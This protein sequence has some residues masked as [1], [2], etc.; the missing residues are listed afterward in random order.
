MQLFR[1]LGASDDPWFRVGQIPATTTVVVSVLGV[2]GMVLWS[3]E[4]PKHAITKYLILNADSSSS[5]VTDGQIWRLLTWPFV[6]RPNILTVLLIAVFW[7]LGSQIEALM[8]R[9]RFTAFVLTLVLLPAVIMSLFEFTPV[10]G[11]ASGL[12][13]LQIS[14]LVAFVTHYSTARFWPGLPGTVLVGILVGLAILNAIASR[15]LYQLLLTVIVVCL[16][17]LLMRGLGFAEDQRWIP[18]LP[19]TAQPRSSGYR[20]PPKRPTRPQ[21]KAQQQRDKP[22]NRHLSAVPPPPADLAQAKIDALLDKI[23]VHGVEGLTESE[24]QTLEQLSKRL[25]DK[26]DDG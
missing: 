25:R 4:G 22:G 7:M 23:G 8:G 24:R 11:V 18:K 9:A 14:L 1:D 19:L 16:A 2:V 13:Y 10:N 21:R 15:S 5:G 26:Q 17:P 6:V 20:H 3:V 12:W